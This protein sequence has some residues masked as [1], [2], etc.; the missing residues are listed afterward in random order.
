[1][2]SIQMAMEA[3]RHPMTVI[4][5]NDPS[6]IQLSEHF[7]LSEFTRSAAAI[8]Y[9]IDNT[10][11][12]EDIEALQCLCIHVLEPLRK[13]F[14]VLKITSGYRSPMLNAKVRGAHNSQHMKGQ[15]ADLFV[16]SNE[17]ARKYYDFIRK[18]LEYDQL[19]LEMKTVRGVG[20]VHCIHVS[21]NNEGENR[22]QAISNYRVK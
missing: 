4:A 10:P 22:R 9:D 7:R 14:G 8:R 15:A 21:Y 19:L 17:V 12:I 2:T 5:F 18:N 11:D 20:Y 1:M 16:S 3:P 6:D 13:K